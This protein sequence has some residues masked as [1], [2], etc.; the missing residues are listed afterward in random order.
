M[1]TVTPLDFQDFI[2]TTADEQRWQIVS[3]IQGQTGLAENVNIIGP[4]DGDGNVKVDL[5]KSS[6]NVDVNNYSLTNIAQ[7]YSALSIPGFNTNNGGYYHLTSTASTNATTLHTR[8]TGDGEP[9]PLVGSFQITNLALTARYLYWMDSTSIIF[10]NALMIFAIPAGQTINYIPS[11]PLY[12][13][14]AISFAM[15]TSGS[16]DRKSTR[17]NSSH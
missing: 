6:A 4:V 8:A 2:G 15:S 17:L 10:A 7:G 9:F 14:N 3:A 11:A 13:Q 12:F 5:V 16:A 1:P